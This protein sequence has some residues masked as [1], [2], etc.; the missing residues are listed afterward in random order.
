[1]NGSI[2]K[3]FSGRFA[4]ALYVASAALLLGFTAVPAFDTIDRELTRKASFGILLLGLA[5]TVF[6]WARVPRRLQLSLP[7]Y[8]VVLA[9]FLPGMINADPTLGYPFLFLVFVWLAVST[10]YAYVL[11]SFALS[12]AL[13]ATAMG[14]ENSIE[15]D[16]ILV[17]VDTLF[18][19]L[20]VGLVLAF[21]MQR[22]QRARGMAKAQ[23][24]AMEVLIA[25][26]E[27]LATELTTDGVGS[28]VA[29][30]AADLLGARWARVVLLDAEAEVLLR[31]DC[32]DCPDGHGAW[33][34]PTVVWEDVRRGATLVTAATEPDCWGN[35]EG[36]GSV[37]WAPLRGTGDPLG[38]VAIGLEQQPVDVGDFARSTIRALASQGALAFERVRLTLSLLDQTMRDE[39]TGV[40]NRRHAM[41]LL[42][43]VSEDDGVMVL[44]L[45][46]FKEVNDTLGHD[47]GD[48][49]L[50]QLAGYLGEALR[51]QDAV[52]R[53]GGDE[54]L[55]ILWGVGDKADEVTQRLVEGWRRRTPMASLSVG[56]AVHES[57]CSAN[58]TFQRADMALYEAKHRGRDRGVVFSPGVVPVNSCSAPVPE[59][60]LPNLDASAIEVTE[61]EVHDGYRASRA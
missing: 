44:D 18:V 9:V 13:V 56:V 49:L 6:P 17:A 1:M 14:F 61:R 24:K 50:V 10:N 58:E 30:Y 53:Y 60:R 37:L 32:G 54:F 55:A 33:E 25:A 23:R 3:E 36:V 2:S 52:A 7:L 11:G 40:G 28:H 15:G 22:L 12:S 57:E 45:D 16:Q 34:M 42:S 8:A 4:G 39:L 21:T 26:V 35:V 19:A 47:R 38:V 41:G 20:V 5:A 27:E 29:Q 43:R 31:Y 51:D 46:H 59:G 48:E